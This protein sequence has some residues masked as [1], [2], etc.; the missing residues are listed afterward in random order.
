[1]VHQGQM[2][3]QSPPAVSWPDVSTPR[4]VPAWGHCCSRNNA[5]QLPKWVNLKAT[6]LRGWE[7]SHLWET[8]SESTGKWPKFVYEFC[9]DCSAQFSRGGHQCKQHQISLFVLEGQLLASQK[10]R[11]W[12]LYL[13]ESWNPEVPL[14]L[15]R[16]GRLLKK[17]KVTAHV[18][19][20]GNQTERGASSSA[21]TMNH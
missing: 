11:F 13:P 17:P 6:V 5:L 20:D 7:Y 19:A 1:M 12:D 18:L 2:W 16:S 3:A 10:F 14:G 15:W 21:G 4:D 9:Q 8:N